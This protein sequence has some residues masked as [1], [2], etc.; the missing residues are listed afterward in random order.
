MGLYCYTYLQRGR[1]VLSPG[2][3]KAKD[4]R[5]QYPENIVEWL[6]PN[7]V[8]VVVSGLE[9]IDLSQ[10]RSSFK[11]EFRLDSGASPNLQW[12]RGC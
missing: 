7:M 11:P 10:T 3:R 1:I 8:V 9:D 5:L 4:A 2:S 12:V 6:E